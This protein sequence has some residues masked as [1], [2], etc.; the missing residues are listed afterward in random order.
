[1]K[2]LLNL[3]FCLVM[4]RPGP[5]AAGY[6]LDPGKVDFP[7]AISN[8]LHFFHDRKGNLSLR[9]VMERDI[10]GDFEKFKVP[11]IGQMDCE[12]AYW[13]RF[14][15]ENPSQMKVDMS[16]MQI[17]SPTPRIELYNPRIS[18]DYLAVT[19]YLVD[20]DQVTSQSYYPRLTFGVFPGENTYYLRH[21]C[22]ETLFLA[23]LLDRAD[24]TRADNQRALLLFCCFIGMAVT[25][26]AMSVIFLFYYRDLIFL[27]QILFNLAIAVAFYWGVA[28]F[29]LFGFGGGINSVA[30]YTPLWAIVFQLCVVIVFRLMG[31]RSRT[32]TIFIYTSNTIVWIFC[33]LY[34]YN[35]Y[36]LSY[37]IAGMI[38]MVGV[39]ICLIISIFKNRDSLFNTFLFANLPVILVGAIVNLAHMTGYLKPSFWT[40]HGIVIIAFYEIVLFAIF[41]SYRYYNERELRNRLMTDNQKKLQETNVYNEVASMYETSEK[42]W[43]LDIAFQMNVS[44]PQP[45]MLQHHIPDKGATYAV[46][47]FV[48]DRSLATSLLLSACSGIASLLFELNISRPDEM[49]F[50]EFLFSLLNQ[51]HPVTKGFSDS[52]SGVGI[53]ILCRHGFEL[54]MACSTKISLQINGRHKE[55]TRTPDAD[56]IVMPFSDG[57]NI[58]IY[59]DGVILI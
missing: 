5:A 16:I 58:T 57:D 44:G 24:N 25:I 37:I 47:C 17:W 30:L 40:I 36:I 7:I 42:K 41:I 43:Q 39:I 48:N 56:Y 9:E 23:Y 27:Y 2:I 54:G 11:L 35:G 19:G 33:F 53:A 26:I 34:F 50:H 3:I 38:Y 29:G 59:K 45:L 28:I 32:V 14:I 31:H 15:I 13:F 12:G 10:K 49:T 1:M 52:S 6:S 20:F 18:M 55:V 46:I 21:V 4:I 51:F 8:D 22:D